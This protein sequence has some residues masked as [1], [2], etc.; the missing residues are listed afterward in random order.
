[1]VVVEGW[2]SKVVDWVS[3]GVLGGG[4]VFVPVPEN[5]IE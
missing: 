1:M 4:E 3:S 2:G 5:G